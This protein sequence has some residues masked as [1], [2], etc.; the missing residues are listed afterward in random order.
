MDPNN[1]TSKRLSPHPS[2]TELGNAPLIEKGPCG[3]IFT[4]S[5]A[6]EIPNWKI[7]DEKSTFDRFIKRMGMTAY[8]KNGNQVGAWT[9]ATRGTKDAVGDVAMTVPVYTNAKGEKFIIFQEEA[10]PIDLLRNGN[11]SRI[12]A[13]PAGVIGDEANFRNESPLECAEREFVEET[14]MNAK[15]FEYLGELN[16]TGKFK[17]IMS[18]P[19]MTDEATHFF[20]ADVKNLRPVSK[21]L[22]DHGITR[23]WWKVPLE[24]LQEWIVEM[25]KLGKPLTSQTST[26]IFKAI[27]KG[28]FHI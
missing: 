22:T 3:S 6:E 25:E 20:Y 4:S 8:D 1:V 19:G 9:M 11:N 18:S 28:K 14:G 17:P 7:T 5:M 27:L 16:T 13:F 12:I 23:G 26:A 21:P 2:Q 15:K 24:N 10:R